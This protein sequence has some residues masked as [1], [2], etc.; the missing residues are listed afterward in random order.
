MCTEM[1]Q[2]NNKYVFSM[3]FKLNAHNCFSSDYSET[4][5]ICT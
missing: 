1:K 4:M 3:L 2:I 5:H